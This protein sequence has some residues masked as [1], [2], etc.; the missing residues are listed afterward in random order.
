ME[1]RAWETEAVLVAMGR[2]AARTGNWGWKEGLDQGSVPFKKPVVQ[3]CSMST[4]K[5]P[6][7]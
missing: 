6:T 7:L 4:L 1:P 3:I 2:E 5:Q